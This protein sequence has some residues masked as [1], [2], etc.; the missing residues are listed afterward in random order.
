ML[1]QLL[2]AGNDIALL[3]EEETQKRGG[4]PFHGLVCSLSVLGCRQFMEMFRAVVVVQH[5]FGFRKDLLDAIPDPGRPI[6]NHTEPYS[7]LR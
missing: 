1:L 7:I 6:G 2:N 3:F 5:L 4:N